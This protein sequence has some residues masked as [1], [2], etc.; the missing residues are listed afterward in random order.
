MLESI[1]I[2][3]VCSLIGSIRLPGYIFFGIGTGL[4]LALDE[5]LFHKMVSLSGW[6][7]VALQSGSLLFVSLSLLGEGP[8]WSVVLAAFGMCVYLVLYNRKK[9][10]KETVLLVLFLSFV[11]I[12]LAFS[13][14][15]E[16]VQLVLFAVSLVVFLGYMYFRKPVSSM[17]GE[18]KK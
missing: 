6:K 4:L 12:G 11:S 16:P 8:W 3:L 1:G 5:L 7:L 15:I 2:F 14:V 13:T 9:E 17:E 10:N 18:G